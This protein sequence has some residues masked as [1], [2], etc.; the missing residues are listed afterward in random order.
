MTVGQNE[1]LR[2][3]EDMVAHDDRELLSKLLRSVPDGC[4]CRQCELVSR[5]ESNVC[6]HCGTPDSLES[7]V[8]LEYLL[9]DSNN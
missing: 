5:L 8:S 3:V 9:P 2:W 7:R 1:R 6:H 4:I